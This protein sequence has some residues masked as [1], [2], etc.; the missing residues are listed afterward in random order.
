MKEHGEIKIE[1]IDPKIDMVV[2][3]RI[4]CEVESNYARELAA[5]L[6][7]PIGVYIGGK[8]L[9]EEAL[10]SPRLQE[11][12]KTR[13]QT[14]IPGANLILNFHHPDFLVVS[15]TLARVE[16][17]GRTRGGMKILAPHYQ[18]HFDPFGKKKILVPI[19]RVETSLIALCYAIHIAKLTDS[20]IVIYHT[21]MPKDGCGSDCW[22][23]HMKE[24]ARKMLEKSVSTCECEGVKFEEE[25]TSVY[26]MLIAEGIACAAL[27]HKCNLIVM[28][29]A[30]DVIFGSHAFQILNYSTIPTL[31]VE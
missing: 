24:N 1:M 18:K 19:G 3:F 22:N 6:N 14:K 15:N 27:D 2:I 13:I 30:S 11:I 28:S 16:L 9:P 25:I 31:I 7:L 10:N 29:I 5:S 17:S 26:P 4:R 8:R 23:D 21:T 20:T 12:Q